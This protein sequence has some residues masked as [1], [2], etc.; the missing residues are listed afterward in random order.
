MNPLTLEATIARATKDF[1]RDNW[2]LDVSSF[3]PTQNRAWVGLAGRILQSPVS[4]MSVKSSNRYRDTK[5][6]SAEN[7]V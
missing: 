1:V 5:K 2:R 7:M 4:M 3:K 6:G